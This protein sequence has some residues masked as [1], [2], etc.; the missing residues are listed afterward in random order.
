MYRGKMSARKRKWGALRQAL[1]PAFGCNA[2]RPSPTV[3]LPSPRAVYPPPPATAAAA[4]PPLLDV[5]SDRIFKSKA[6]MC[7]GHQ[8]IVTLPGNGAW[9]WATKFNL[10]CNSVTA[11]V[12]P[13]D[14]GGASW[15]TRPS[16]GLTK[17]GRGHVCS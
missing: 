15:E 7:R 9:S 5:G 17:V 13:V 4:Y 14:A 2:S 8:V 6:A 16:L 3:S 11:M 1:L 12:P 10:L